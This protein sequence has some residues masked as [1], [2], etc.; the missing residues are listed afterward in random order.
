MVKNSLD[1]F[2]CFIKMEPE[3]VLHSVV[4]KV[5]TDFYAFSVSAVTATTVVEFVKIKAC[6]TTCAHLVKASVKLLEVLL[7]MSIIHY[8][9]RNNRL[10]DPRGALSNRLPQKVIAIANSEI[11]KANQPQTRKRGSYHHYSP[12]ERVKI[13]QKDHESR[14]GKRENDGGRGTHRR[15]QQGGRDFDENWRSCNCWSY[16]GCDAAN[17]TPIAGGAQPARKELYA[18]ER[19]LHKRELQIW[20]QDLRA[21]Q[22]SREEENLRKDQE[23]SLQLDI[24]RTIVEEIHDQ[25]E[26]NLSEHEARDKDVKLTNLMD[27]D[28]IEAYLT[29]FERQMTAYEVPSGHWVFKLAPQL[30]GRAEQAYSADE[31]SD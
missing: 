7:I 29:T 8:S 20:D 10:P 18:E 16:W 28:D 12:E 11:R 3:L 21:E 27:N 26:A 13:G 22:R 4:K 17:A 30:S 9:E 19:R 31:S 15:L 14:R 2:A 1:Y 23:M 6:V 5:M 24:L 25:D